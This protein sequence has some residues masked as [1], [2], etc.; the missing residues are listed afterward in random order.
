[1]KSVTGGTKCIKTPSGKVSTYFK[2]MNHHVCADV[3][4]FASLIVGTVMWDDWRLALQVND[5]GQAWRLHHHLTTAHIYPTKS[6]QMRNHLAEQVFN[7]DM[8]ILL[9]VGQP[10]LDCYMGFGAHCL[11]PNPIVFSRKRKP[12]ILRRTCQPP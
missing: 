12:C 9:K 5:S 4:M 2:H 3:Q 11:P 10:F 8:L 1:M 6:Q 7:E